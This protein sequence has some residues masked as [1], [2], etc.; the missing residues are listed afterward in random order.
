[1][2]GEHDEDKEHPQARGGDREDIEGDQVPD[3]VA[4][5]RPPGLGRRG[6]PLREEPGDGPLGHLDPQLPSSPWIRGAPHRGFAA[7]IRVTRAL[8]SALTG[9]RPQSAGG[10]AWSS[11]R[12]SAAA[13]TATRCLAP[14]SRGPPSTQSRPW[15]ARPPEGDPSG[16]AWAA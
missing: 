6:L 12:E 1:M 11:A 16:V 15:P 9:G 14:R 7:A 10:K 8:I 5:E 4:E 2:V 13:A 3:V